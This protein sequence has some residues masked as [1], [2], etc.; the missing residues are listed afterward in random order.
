MNP[1]LFPYTNPV[2]EDEAEYSGG[3]LE[4][5]EH[6]EEDCV[7]GEQRRVLS[8]RADAAREADDE[9]DGA[10]PDEDE[11]GVEG[12]VGHQAQVVE[13]VL[14]GPRPHADGEHAQADQ[15]G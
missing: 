2:L 7:G 3:H 10:G 13:G 6:R 4:Q 9:G 5:E 1:I 12:D 15:L 14:L 11:G 8:Q